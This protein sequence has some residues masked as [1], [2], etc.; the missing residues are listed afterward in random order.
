MLR[1]PCIVL[2]A[3][4]AAA[5]AAPAAAAAGTIVWSKGGDIWAMQ[6][7]G[8]NPRLF[9]PKSAAP[10]M[11][12]L[13]NPGIHPAGTVLTFEGSTTANEVRHL[14]LCGTFPSQY[15]CWT[16]H[17]G[18]NATGVYRWTGGTTVE[19]LTGAPAYCF[20]CTNSSVAPEPRADGAIA[21]ATHHCQGWLED[22]SYACVGALNSTTGESYPSCTD[23]PDEPSPNPAAPSQLVY[24]G[25]TSGGNPALIVTGPDRAGE[26]PVGCDDVAQDD[27]SWSPT[28][29]EVV[30]A[31][32]GTDPGIWVYGAGNTAC[33]AGAL[34][35]AVVA[36]AGVAF[37]S[38]RH[39]G[40]RI[41]FE[42]QGDLW[43]VPAGCT[44]CAFPSGATQLTTGGDNRDPAWTAAALPATSPVVAVPDGGGAGGTA[45]PVPAPGGGAVKDTTAPV[46]R[47]TVTTRQRI[48]R[49][50]KRIVLKL[51][52]SETSTAT[53]TATITVPGRDPKLTTVRRRLPAGSSVTV[54]LAVGAKALRAV[55]RAW[56]RGKRPVAVVRLVVRDVAGNTTR[57]TLR[58]T[59][60]R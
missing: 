5:L 17:Y 27:P 3:A 16:W 46:V 32:G 43:S 34:R 1:R 7:D 37:R 19:R 29:G 45:T 53:L 8:T 42:A 49:Q 44:A 10:G 23:L 55:R 25:C 48:L 13:Q 6:D 24:T 9:I 52:A 56:A 20:N 36:P 15:S 38:P 22:G 59:L 41:V 57:R 50:G 4:A 21:S 14:G 47:V 30:A 60:R 39:T 18:F 58:I 28:G 2:L 33:F 26:R 11:T 54:R 12:T 51:R 31:E 40:A 35:H